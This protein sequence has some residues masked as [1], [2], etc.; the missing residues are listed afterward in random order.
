VREFAALVA[1]LSPESVFRAAVA[2]EPVEMSDQ[3]AQA[4]I[5]TL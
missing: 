5:A 3:D 4:L 2:D 1:G